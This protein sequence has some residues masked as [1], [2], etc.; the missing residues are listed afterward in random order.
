MQAGYCI[1]QPRSIKRFFNS[2]FIESRGNLKRNYVKCMT[3]INC[4]SDWTS[5]RRRVLSTIRL[6]PSSFCVTYS[7]PG[8]GK[9]DMFRAL[10]ANNDRWPNN[11]CITNLILCNFSPKVDI[12]L[13]EW[14]CLKTLALLFW[15]FRTRPTV[16][17]G[18]VLQ[19]PPTRLDYDV[20]RDLG[21]AS[22]LV[23]TM[24]VLLVNL[25]ASTSFCSTW[26]VAQLSTSK[27][28]SDA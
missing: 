14:Y 20:P 18:N 28:M 13:L 7:A 21:A 27:L 23:V 19:Y 25:S 1:Q 17:S 15:S 12:A 11:R 5:S 6:V 26:K 8:I 3:S 2:S 4:L 10:S 24:L 9:S 22:S 16:M